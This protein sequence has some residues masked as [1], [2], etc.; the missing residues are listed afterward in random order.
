M[1][2]LEDLGAALALPE[3]VAALAALERLV[4]ARVGARLY[5]VMAFDAA[6]G[7]SSR[8]WTNAPDIYP[9]GGQKPLPANRWTDLVIRDRKDW[10]AN[11]PPEVAELLFD[12]QTIAA[13]GCGACLNMPIVVAGQVL[14]TVNLLDAAGHFTPE[15]L[16]AA[17]S[18]KLP[19]AAV[20]MRQRMAA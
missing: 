10:V 11:T 3:P 14:G 19:A 9:V 17:R 7:L 18:L 13:L 8:I 1:D 6:T 4:Q 20:L 12:H 5:T 2:G 16:A 15:R